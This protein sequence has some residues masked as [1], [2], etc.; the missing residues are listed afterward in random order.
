PHA[1]E[2][3]RK[4]VVLT[5]SDESRSNYQIRRAYVTLG[6][7][8]AASGQAQ[9]SELFLGKARDLQKKTMELTQQQIS[10]V[11][12]EGGGTLAAVVPLDSSRESV[13]VTPLSDNIDHIACVDVATLT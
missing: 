10:S 3:L 4:A 2:Y 6:R 11:I 12:A 13:V 8:F 5:G 7:I 9:E 1:E